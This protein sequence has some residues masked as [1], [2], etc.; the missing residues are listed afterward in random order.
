MTTPTPEPNPGPGRPGLAAVLSMGLFI[1][2]A[3]YVSYSGIRLGLLL[4]QRLAGG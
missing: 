3:G 2:L 1:V 4:W